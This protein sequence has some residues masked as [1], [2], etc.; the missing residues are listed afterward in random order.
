MNYL[1]ISH[2]FFS[3]SLSKILVLPGYD[4]EG[5]K[6]FIYR[7]CLYRNEFLSIFTQ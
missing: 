2:N 7:E 3:I 1:F 6:V 4:D 5:R